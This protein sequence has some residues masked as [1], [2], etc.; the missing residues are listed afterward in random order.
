MNDIEILEIIIENK[1][2]YL[3]TIKEFIK[4]YKNNL[5]K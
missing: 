3:K 1:I 5:E 4:K 2:E